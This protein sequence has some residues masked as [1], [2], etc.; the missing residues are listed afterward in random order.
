MRRVGAAL[1]FCRGRQLN[2]AVILKAQASD[3][4]KGKHL[5]TLFYFSSSSRPPARLTASVCFVL[6]FNAHISHFIMCRN[7]AERVG[8]G[9]CHS[10]CATKQS[11]SSNS[12][13][14]VFIIYFLNTKPYMLYPSGAKHTRVVMVRS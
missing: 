11:C 8:R 13:E 10:I 9:G 5:L 3:K 14:S 4:L 7:S 1:L 2:N 6:R 12:Y